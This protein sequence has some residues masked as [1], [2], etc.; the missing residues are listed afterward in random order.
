MDSISQTLQG[1]SLSNSAAA[2]KL[3]PRWPTIHADRIAF[4]FDDHL[5][6]TVNGVAHRISSGTAQVR[7]PL[8]SPDGTR[9]A[10]SAIEDDCEEVYCVNV[11]G[12]N[13]TRLTF[14]GTDCGVVSWAPDGKA[15][16]FHSFW[17]QQLPEM[18]GI[19]AVPADGGQSVPIPYATD[20]DHL[21]FNPAGV[22][23][24]L[25]RNCGDPAITEWKRCGCSSCPLELVVLYASPA[26]SAGSGSSRAAI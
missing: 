17:R 22:G 7:R 11:D 15:I 23:V 14:T 13:P 21:V 26:G 12:S 4:V 19:F 16:Y 2:S 8:F 5:W 3:Y 10:F 24:M 9:I 6:L 18:C 25:G 20:A 1:L